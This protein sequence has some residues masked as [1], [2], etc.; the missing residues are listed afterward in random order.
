MTSTKKK[1]RKV[2]KRGLIKK[3][4][5]VFSLWVRT[6]DADFNGMVHCYT[7]PAFKHWKQMQ[8]GH[9]ISRVYYSLRWEPDNCRVQCASCNL[10]HQGEQYTFGK[11][12]EKELGNLR[13][14]QMREIKNHA[15][16]FSV[17]DYLDKIEYFNSRLEEVGIK[18]H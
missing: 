4:D 1:G 11:N 14:E 17:Q 5:T 13:I 2:S 9:F 8:C 16:G 18:C 7:C 10:Y 6:K 12:L 3:L 15:S